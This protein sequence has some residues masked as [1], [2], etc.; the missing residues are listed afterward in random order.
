MGAND[1]VIVTLGSMTAAS[2]LGAMD[3]APVLNGKTDSGAWHFGKRSPRAGPSSGDPSVFA[4]HVDESKW[5]SFTTTLH[6]PTLFRLVRDLT[7]NVPGEGGLI[8]FPDSGWLMSIVLPHQPH[9]IGQPDD[10]KV[11]W[12]YGFLVDKPGDFVGKPMS[13][14]TGREIM[15]EILGHLR[16]EADADRI[17]EH[18]DLHSLHDAVHH[19]PVSAAKPGDRPDVVPTGWQI[20]P[21]P[22]SSASCPTMSC[23]PSNTRFGRPR[24]RFTPCS[25]SSASRQRSIK[26]S[27]IRGCC[28]GRSRACTASTRDLIRSSLAGQ[29]LARP[30]LPG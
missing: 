20:S 28:T 13:A 5:L 10:V 8:T 29:K 30:R 14:C 26:G 3:S 16:I 12:G 23:S 27:S 25:D 22:A 9:F 2:S 7:G 19:E 24:P 15:T 1:N 21:S 17:L 18:A 6:D 11:L 4:D